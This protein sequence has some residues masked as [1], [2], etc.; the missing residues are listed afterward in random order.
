[1]LVEDN[2]CVQQKFMPNI[3]RRESNKGLTPKTH[4]PIFITRLIQTVKRLCRRRPYILRYYEHYILEN[5]LITRKI[6]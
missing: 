6:R 5:R 2:Y 3:A 4:A 1:M